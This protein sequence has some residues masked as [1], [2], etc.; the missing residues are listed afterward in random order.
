MNS[1]GPELGLSPAP[2]PPS[3]QLSRWPRVLLLVLAS[4]VLIAGGLTAGVF[5][6]IHHE[7]DHWEPLYRA[8]VNDVSRWK[9][10]SARWQQ[11]SRRVQGQLSSLQSDVSS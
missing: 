4:T 10:D 7:R 2:A 5:L 8:A 3:E 11:R 6:G 9:T 1:S